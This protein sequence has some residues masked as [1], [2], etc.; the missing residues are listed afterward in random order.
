M[1]WLLR[2]HQAVNIH[3]IDDV[4]WEG[5][6]LLGGSRYTTSVRS[7]WRNHTKQL[8]NINLFLNNILLRGA[9]PFIFGS[10]NE[11]PLCCWLPKAP[12]PPPPPPPTPT[13]PPPP[14]VFS[15]GGLPR[16]GTTFWTKDY[17]GFIGVNSG[18]I[19]GPIWLSTVSRNAVLLHWIPFHVAL[20]W[21][22]PNF[23]GN[24]ALLTENHIFENDVEKASV[25]FPKNMKILL[26]Q[27]GPFIARFII[28]NIL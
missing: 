3:S 17:N 9:K 12:P 15:S 16:G 22:S 26:L 8:K 14:S 2:C 20:S 27:W 5:P 7:M 13:T 19:K 24:V 25:C 10:L 6:C 23:Y 1:T 21:Y 18:L 28:A 4:T 11:H